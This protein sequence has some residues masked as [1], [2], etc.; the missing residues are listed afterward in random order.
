MAQCFRSRRFA[1]ASAIAVPALAEAQFALLST[2]AGVLTCRLPVA[3]G[4]VSA[5]EPRAI[6]A[7][8]YY[9]L[10][11]SDCG[12]AGALC[13]GTREVIWKVGTSGCFSR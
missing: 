13:G 3:R 8:S 9:P 12:C 4:I 7:T 6:A 5:V 2:R 11:S 10:Q 1:S